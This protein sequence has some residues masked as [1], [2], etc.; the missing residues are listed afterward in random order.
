M[1][2]QSLGALSSD[3]IMAIELLWT[4]RERGAFLTRQQMLEDYAELRSI[5][6]A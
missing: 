6:R 2:L 5:T 3:R 1:T 4:P